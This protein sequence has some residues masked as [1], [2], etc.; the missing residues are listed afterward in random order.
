LCKRK[1]KTRRITM[2]LFPA[3]KKGGGFFWG[4]PEEQRGREHKGGLLPKVGGQALLK[5]NY[6]YQCRGERFRER[7]HWREQGK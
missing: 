4:E 6:F 2:E 1:E 5:L 3:A 7:F